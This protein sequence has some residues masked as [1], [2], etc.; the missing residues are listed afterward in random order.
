MDLLKKHADTCVILAGV[1]GSFLWMNGS[2]NDVK[3]EVAHLQKDVAIVKTV[4]LMKN[5]M[6]PE[7]AKKE[8]KK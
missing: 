1:I 7:L 8:D 3:K 4:L 6:P 5:I 2:I